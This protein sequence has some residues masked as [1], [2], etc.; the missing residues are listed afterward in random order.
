MAFEQLSKPEI[1]PCPKKH[2]EIKIIYTYMHDIDSTDLTQFA[3][4]VLSARDI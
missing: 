2:L 4:A 3:A 1:K